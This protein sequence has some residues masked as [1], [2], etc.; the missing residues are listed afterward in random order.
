MTA[1]RASRAARAWSPAARSCAARSHRSRPG[2]AAT[3]H[4]TP[5]TQVRARR[6]KTSIGHVEDRLPGKRP[7][8]S[9]C[10]RRNVFFFENLGSAR[11]ARDAARRRETPSD[12]SGYVLGDAHASLT[13][14]F[15]Y[16]PPRSSHTTRPQTRSLIKK[17]FQTKKRRRRAPLAP[18]RL[19][20][21]AG[22]GGGDGDAGARP[23]GRVVSARERGRA[24]EGLRREGARGGEGSDREPGV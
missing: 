14:R 16:F 1:L 18:P 22:A 4:A 21:R 12:S 23:R 11:R 17:K 7:S 2:P 13:P 6:A 19:P 5:P 24:P 15:L 9:V 20:R 8:V 3:K 10:S